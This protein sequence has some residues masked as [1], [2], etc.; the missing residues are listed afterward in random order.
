VALALRL[1]G[2]L[3]ALFGV[4]GVVTAELEENVPHISVSLSP[5]HHNGEKTL[6][7]E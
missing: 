1:V 5:E 7:W 2:M 4:I 3:R 6:T